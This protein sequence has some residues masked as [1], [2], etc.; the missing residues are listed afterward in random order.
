M[1]IQAPSKYYKWMVL[2]SIGTGVFL[3]TIDGSIV[4]VTLPT[5]VKALNTNFPIIQWVVLAYLLTVTTL[6]LSIGRLGDMVGKKPLFMAG[7]IIFTIG[8]I[9]CGLAG[10]VFFLILFRV[11]QAVGASM[12]MALSSA[13]VTEAFPPDERG[14]ALGLHGTMV[15]VGIIAGPTIGGLIL[16]AF[17]WHWI[18]FVNIPVGLIGIWM[19]QKYVP[20]KKPAGGQKFDFLGAIALFVS[21]LSLLFG[22]TM[23]QRLSFS[24]FRVLGLFG[25]GIIFLIAFIRIE[26]RVDQPMVDLKLFNNTLFSINLI[27]GFLAFVAS[28]GTI[29]LMPFYLQNV[30][31]YDPSKT[32]LLMAAVPLI[33][34][35]VAP[36]A[37]GLSDRYGTR[38]L[39][40]IGLMILILGYM[41]V[42][43]LNLTTSAWGYI[44]RFV[45]VGIG[46]GIF[47]SPNNSAIMGAVPHSRLGVASGLLSITRTM[48]QTTG[49]A[50]LG[51]L[52]T[53]NVA[54]QV[55][56]GIKDVSD[57][58]LSAQVIGLEQTM[59]F[60]VVLI[61]VAW[62]LSVWALRQ[63]IKMKKGGT[64]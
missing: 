59:W 27:T 10:N 61:F 47:Q 22:L 52:W 9:F 32:G 7:Q 23:G 17:S 21:L 35:V 6:M 31:S 51:A 40:V 13:I 3:A 5:L 49:I 26:M 33:I 8:S 30:L 48:G 54:G 16:Q 18:F 11:F 57:A 28:A 15:S 62:I 25:C 60:V 20:N 38:P 19:V 2:L 56:F 41:A 64:L 46:V 29:F 63:W 34:G 53:I 39:A 1:S 36:L 43:T 14:K 37:G 45:L 12:I 44:L 24:D 50:L 42:S 58:P 4:N 55:E